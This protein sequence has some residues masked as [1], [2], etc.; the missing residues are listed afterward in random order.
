MKGVFSLEI[1]LFGYLTCVPFP[2]FD[3]TDRK[4]L[5]DDY[6]YAM[7]GK[8]FKYSQEKAPSVKVYALHCLFCSLADGFLQCRLRILRRTSHDA[9]R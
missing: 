6:Q 7:Y 2:A 8:V 9:E 3:Q 5:L 1:S 4:T